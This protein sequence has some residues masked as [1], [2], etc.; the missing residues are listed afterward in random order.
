MNISGLVITFNEESNIKDCIISLNR[1]CDE[2][3]IIDSFSKDKTVEIAESMGA[4]IYSQ[5]FLGDGLQR[6]H[7]LQFCKNDAVFD[8]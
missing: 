2:V 5:E 6:V 8:N 4:K 7:G 3:I 1:V